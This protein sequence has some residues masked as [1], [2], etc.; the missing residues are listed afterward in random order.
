[1]SVISVVFSPIL[2]LVSKC[3]SL[4]LFF[5]PFF[6]WSVNVCHFCCFFTQTLCLLKAFLLHQTQYWMFLHPGT[7]SLFC[8]LAW[9][10]LLLHL[11]DLQGRMLL[12]HLTDHEGQ[13]HPESKKYT[14]LALDREW[15][16]VGSNPVIDRL[17]I[18]W[19]VTQDQQTTTEILKVWAE[20]LELKASTVHISPVSLTSVCD[21]CQG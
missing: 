15:Q 3:L 11:C 9:T 20:A 12:G 19:Q 6:F 2:F 21:A 17:R 1:M 18:H 10:L 16:V 13:S 5:H 4:L 7:I 8:F 14:L